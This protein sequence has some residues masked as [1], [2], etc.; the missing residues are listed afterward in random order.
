[1]RKPTASSR[2][3]SG[4]ELLP[5]LDHRSRWLRRFRDLTALHLSDLGGLDQA[6]ESEKAIVRRVACIIVELEQ[7]EERFAVRTARPRSSS[8]V[9]ALIVVSSR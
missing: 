5:G 6:S 3:T 8:L 2:I 7:I 9:S 1:M 4:H